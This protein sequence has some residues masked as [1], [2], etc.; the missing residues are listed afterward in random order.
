MLLVFFLTGVESL[1]ACTWLSPHS[2]ALAFLFPGT[3]LEAGAFTPS[4]M[5]LRP[6]LFLSRYPT[7]LL[8]AA[9]P[10]IAALR[11]LVEATDVGSLSL[12]LRA[13]VRVYYSA[14]TSAN[15]A[16]QVLPRTDQGQHALLVIM[17]SG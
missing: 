4:G 6:I 16:F 15:L 11:S 1:Q 10:G 13:D 17:L 2:F 9:G 14:P 3:E 5:D 12:G 7:V 8:F